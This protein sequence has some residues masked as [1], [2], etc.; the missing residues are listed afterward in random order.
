MRLTDDD[1]LLLIDEAA[2]FKHMI[3]TEQMHLVSQAITEIP[4]DCDER[5]AAV[6]HLGKVYLRVRRGIMD[7]DQLS[8]AIESKRSVFSRRVRATEHSMRFAE[9]LYSSS[10]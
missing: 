10:V 3:S 6:K 9:L 1:R 8:I 2:E 5:Y 4:C 7:V